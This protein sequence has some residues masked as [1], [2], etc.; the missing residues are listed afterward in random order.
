M[1]DFATMA[2]LLVGCRG[3]NFN[4][5]QHRFQKM[6]MHESSNSTLN[7]REQTNHMVTITFRTEQSYTIPIFK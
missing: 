4:T 6:F 5:L 3:K 1:N 2:F 7:K